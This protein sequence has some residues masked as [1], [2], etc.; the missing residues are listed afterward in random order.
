MSA[1]SSALTGADDVIPRELAL[2][3]AAHL[4]NESGAILTSRRYPIGHSISGP[5][6][7]DI[8]TWLAQNEAGG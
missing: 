5:E 1:P 6:I 2:R 3:S 7:V 8:A 4:E